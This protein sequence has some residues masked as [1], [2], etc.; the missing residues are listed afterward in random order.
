ML[1]VA[2][3]TALAKVSQKHIID[4]VA[5]ES[6]RVE[7]RHVLFVFFALASLPFAFQFAVMAGTLDAA[8]IYASHL[9]IYSDILL[10][11]LAAIISLRIRLLSAFLKNA[12]GTRFLPPR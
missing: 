5:K 7:R 6:L 8:L 11:S 12:L 1:K 10:V 2:P 9:A 3:E 4:V